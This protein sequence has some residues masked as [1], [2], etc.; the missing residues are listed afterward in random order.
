MPAAHY[1]EPSRHGDTPDHLDDL[2]A[3]LPAEFRDA[4]DTQ[5]AQLWVAWD[6]A[7]HGHPM[8]YLTDTLDVLPEIA[9][10]LIALAQPRGNEPE[11]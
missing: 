8:S 7:H 6:A 3:Q 4:P 10:P 11:P 9:E 5:V 1:A 2:R